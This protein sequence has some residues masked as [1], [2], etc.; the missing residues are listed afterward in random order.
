MY[1]NVKRTCSWTNKCTYWQN[2]LDTSVAHLCLK[3]STELEKYQYYSLTRF[4]VSVE[5]QQGRNE[6]CYKI[7]LNQWKILHFSSWV[8]IDP[9]YLINPL[10]NCDE[11]LFIAAP[12]PGFL[13]G[14][15]QWSCGRKPII[16]PM[17]SQNL[18]E[19]ERIIEP[20]RRRVFPGPLKS[21]TA[22]VQVHWRATG[23]HIICN[24]YKNKHTRKY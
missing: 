11:S 22:L 24:F 17:F 18:C 1:I 23:S 19:I 8:S 13:W 3:L 21:A 12:D 14:R 9:F 2:T 5:K 6:T 15:Q 20:R 7:T 4:F 16:L 10:W